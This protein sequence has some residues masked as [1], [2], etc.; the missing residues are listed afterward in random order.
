ML[1]MY[2]STAVCAEPPMTGQTDPRLQPFDALLIKFV[3][4]YKVPGA[5]LA[6]T[7]QG[8]LIYARGC[9]LADV[10][11]QLPVQP[12]SQFRIASISK[13]ITAVAILQLVEQ[14]KLK[15]DACILDHLQPWVV[16]TPAEREAHPWRKITVQHCLQHLGGWDGEASFDPMFRSIRIAAALKIPSPPGATDVVRYMSNR[17]LDFTPGERFAYSNFGYNILGRIIEQ[18]SG[19]SYAQ[20]IQDHIWQPVGAR[21]PRLG[22]TLLKDR[23]PGEVLYY[24]PGE[25]GPSVFAET[26]SQ[27]VP[28]PYGRFCVEAFDAHGGWIASAVDLVRFASSLDASSRTPLLKPDT[29]QLIINCRPAVSA[30][31]LKDGKPK[32]S[33]YGLGWSVRPEGDAGGAHL[34]HHGAIDGTSTL[35]VHRADDFNWAILFNTRH[36]I[37]KK[38]PSQQA[39]TLL[40]EAADAIKEWPEID[41]FST[42]SP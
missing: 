10:E 20:Y 16:L 8:R 11:Q 2:A 36:P 33:Y 32:N 14:G 21:E 5:A 28:G 22:K 34:W 13:P 37:D 30:G 42:S 6:V 3:R 15:L 25:H 17:P 29:R 24:E 1:L 40:H 23:A 12:H 39:D 9:G 27:D 7:R 19:K 35:L 18:V 4:E 26:L 38:L 31:F 41:L